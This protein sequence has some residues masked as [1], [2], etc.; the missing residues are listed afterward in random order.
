MG[1]FDILKVEDIDFDSTAQGFGHY[2]I[3]SK[4]I[5]TSEIFQMIMSGKR[6]DLKKLVDEEI[7][8]N[9]H[10]IN[11]YLRNKLRRQP[12]EK[13]LTEFVIRAIM[14]EATHAGMGFDQLP[15]DSAA[16]E[17]G[18]F[19]GQFPDNIFY[20]LKSYLNHPVIETQVIPPA[21][22]MMLGVKGS[23]GKE[24]IEETKKFVAFAEVLTDNLNVDTRTKDKIKNKLARLEVTARTQK[25]RD[26]FSEVIEPDDINSWI[27]RYGEEHK[28]FFEKIDFHNRF[29]NKEPKFSDEELKMVGAVSTTSA[30]AM[31]NKVVRGRKK[32]R[33]KDE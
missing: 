27:K 31:F 4:P 7:R 8:I 32:R 16:K 21:L 19:T 18:A 26:T 6:P 12:T 33:K 23:V 3:S 20:R 2:G 5:N 13:E 11:R 28:K 30:P 15:M 29:S 10:E 24:S 25:P 1:W 17:Y 22:E 14:H 9:H